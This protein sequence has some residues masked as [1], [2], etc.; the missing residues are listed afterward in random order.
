VREK[1]FFKGGEKR[2][3]EKYQL[4]RKGFRVRERNSR[5]IKIFKRKKR[6]NNNLFQ[7]KIMKRHPEM[8]LIENLRV[9]TLIEEASHMYAKVKNQ[10]TLINSTEMH[11][12]VGSLV[13]SADDM[14][15]AVNT[16]GI[17]G[18]NQGNL[19]EGEGSVQLTFLY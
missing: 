14:T 18:P 19:T 16:I 6:F 5:E 11:V 13:V 3:R 15:Q 2:E 17:R 9:E 8:Q 4:E 1:K 7:A 12:S 10:W